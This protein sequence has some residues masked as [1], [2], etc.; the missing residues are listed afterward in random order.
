MPKLFFMHNEYCRQSMRYSLYII[1]SIFLQYYLPYFPIPSC[2][3]FLLSLLA[4]PS[5]FSYTRHVQ[6]LRIEF[7]VLKNIMNK[8]VLESIRYF[9]MGVLTTL[10]NY[11]VYH[12]L[13]LLLQKQS[14]SSFFSYK[15]SYGVAFFLAVVFAYYG[16]K[17][18]VFQKR[19]KKGIKEF[20]SF[21]SL[22]VFSGIAS[23]FLLV[24]FV[25]ILHFSHGLGW[26]GSSVINLL[27]NY[28][29][30]KFLIFK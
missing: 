16:N 27:G 30:S 5:L 15:I 2:Y 3:P 10:V 7:K 26:L 14:V 6:K 21:F 22:R 20:L 25:D 17:F 1:F 24:F 8:Q 4:F 12:A 19:E 13:D 18:F 28:F 9:V 23:F 11:V 29:A